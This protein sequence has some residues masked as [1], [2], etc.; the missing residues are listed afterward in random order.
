M[1]LKWT[2]PS[3]SSRSCLAGHSSSN[4]NCRMQA[5][6]ALVIKGGAMLRCDLNISIW[7]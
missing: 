4:D 7:L 6:T 5:L 2:V 3:W 1:L